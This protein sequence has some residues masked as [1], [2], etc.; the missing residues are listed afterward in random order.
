MLEK[1]GLPP[2]PSLRGNNWVVDATHCQGCSSQF[3]FINRKHHCRRCGGLFCNNCTQQRMM[4]RGQG[5]SPVRICDPCKKLEEAARFELRHGHKNRTGRGTSK[6]A[7]RDED[8]VLN[9][10][11]AN[12]G[13]ESFSIG[14]DASIG[15]RSSYTSSPSMQEIASPDGDQH[16]LRNLSVDETN[17]VHG[18]VGSASPEELRQQSLDEKNKYKILKGEG[19]SAE[20]LSAFKR[21]KELERQAASL[22]LQLR[23][24]RRKALVASSTAEMQK[25]EDVPQES[26]S[27]K[28]SFHEKGKEKDDL[29]AE[30]K[31][32]GWSDM[33]LHVADRKPATT[34][35]ESELFNLMGGNSRKVN[36]DKAAHGIDRTE[37][38]ALKKKALMLK[39]DGKLAEAKEE[40]KKAKI[41]EKQLEEEELLAGAEDSDDEMSALIRSLDS[42]K[43]DDLSIG[44]DLGSGFDVDN[45]VS[46]SGDL[47]LDGDFDVTDDDMNDPE[48]A[49]ALQSFGW[50]EESN[51]F[52]KSM[53]QSISFSEDALENEV[54]NLKKEAVN[55]KRSGNVAEA[56]SL[57]RK[58][59]LLEKD[60]NS[61]ES[62][63]PADAQRIPEI[64]DS[65]VRSTAVTVNVGPKQAPK[66]KLMIQKELL[67]LKKKALAL[68]R[69][70]KVDE[71]EEE[72]KK[73]KIL[74]QQLEEIDKTAKTKVTR[75]NA[76]PE[77][78]S[79]HSDI[80]TALDSID[81]REGDVTDQDMNDPT[82]L[83]LLKSLGWQDED[84][85]H[86]MSSA[87]MSEPKTV[88]VSASVKEPK[89]SKP[90]TQR[91]LLGLKRKALALRRQGQAV[92]AEE[93]LEKA[94]VLEAQ[95][96]E[97]EAP[98][99]EVPAGFSEPRAEVEVLAE[100]ASSD[101]TL[102]RENG[103]NEPSPAT[104][105]QPRSR[106]EI[107][108]ELLGLK[109]KALTL[110]RQGQSA[111]AEELLE[112]AK[113]LEAQ[114]AELE[115]PVK[116]NLIAFAEPKAEVEAP[117]KAASLDYT[118]PKENETG[119][120]PV[121]RAAEA[122]Y[123]AGK[124]EETEHAVVNEASLNPS[125]PTNDE[126]SVRQEILGHK[127][128]AVALKRE[129]KLTEA[130]EEL[131]KAKL[132][133]RNLGEDKS[134]NLASSTSTEVS[135]SSS[136]FKPQEELGPSNVAPKP[137][138]SH[139]RFK[140]QRECL[141]H[142][143]N[144][145]K[146]R[147]EGQTEEAESELQLA[148]TLEVQLEESASPDPTK[149]SSREPGAVNDAGVED[150][151]DPQLMSALTAIGMQDIH[152][153]SH[154][155]A[156]EERSMSNSQKSE[157]SVLERAQLEAQ[158]KAEKVRALN[159]KRS[160]KQ[161][162]ALDA[163]RL[164]KQLEKKLNSLP[165]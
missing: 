149:P 105:N 102:P 74:E 79:K 83:T 1:I 147:R 30:L 70:G 45:L 100:V 126:T 155:S 95:L 137:L 34:S 159:L 59:K 54:L 63:P 121:E 9:Q 57:L 91:E 73:G 160:G 110:R 67:G 124:R 163:L 153:I 29:T 88:A 55:Q 47:A 12:D 78:A 164:A 10:L 64:N 104:F 7:S 132:L 138:S 97:L 48:M 136:T 38:A 116:D 133:E 106:A 142:K 118:G 165:S 98:V 161:A 49:A 76:F 65:A 8:E 44:Y 154:A 151:L 13:K 61:F 158:I 120:P 5:D 162:E 93:L 128:K 27:G 130:R 119:E 134:Q 80:S 145:L 84:S 108:R 87:E 23:K 85:E 117:D 135:T 15:E 36:S 82:Y 66:S 43:E 2:K 146:L 50:N 37:V 150:L 35:L 115:A 152:G 141:A 131:R 46:Y 69:E 31:A 77:P 94:K 40:L 16:A 18:E 32:L 11:L 122:T 17:N 24:N 53:M 52:P 20:A 112:K 96:A 148:R 111:E 103:H 129:G 68:R 123:V 72:L 60:L 4:L 101:Y 125:I 42:G 25:N 127:R 144:A 41:L 3:T 92:E 109:R 39:R 58:A 6:L 21:A 75:V 140:L 114:M 71:A 56:M 99:T 26:H 107:Q 51:Q 89:R 33:D 139:D 156:R 28:R 86:K 19:K 14:R 62:H 143:R 90:D 157:S 22:E 81:E 113:V